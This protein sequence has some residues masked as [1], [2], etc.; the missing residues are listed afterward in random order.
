MATGQWNIDVLFCGGYCDEQQRNALIVNWLQWIRL[1]LAAN[2]SLR[3]IISVRSAAKR[4]QR[5]GK[6][7][8]NKNIKCASLNWC[9]LFFAFF[10]EFRED[11]SF[12][13]NGNETRLMSSIS[14]STESK[15]ST[16]RRS[17]KNI[18]QLK[19]PKRTVLSTFGI[20]Y[21]LQPKKMKKKNIKNCNIRE[22]A[23]IN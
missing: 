23:L 19:S 5:I 15:H 7:N 10:L 4:M 9:E 20:I 3:T 16:E 2:C 12:D 1:E 11:I 21:L 22:F 8:K 6:P 14:A 17:Q 13:G 18:I